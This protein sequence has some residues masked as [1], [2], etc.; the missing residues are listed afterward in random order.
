[1]GWKDDGLWITWALNSIAGRIVKDVAIA[2]RARE[3]IR[4]KQHFRAFAGFAATHLVS[5]L[6][7]D[8]E[9]AKQIMLDW[10]DGRGSIE[11]LLRQH[12]QSLS[13]ESLE[14]TI[15]AHPDFRNGP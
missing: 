15:A 4:D 10:N 7:G 5:A 6:H 2:A 13:S 8:R 11:D 3:F 1:V 12:L 14:K 9:T